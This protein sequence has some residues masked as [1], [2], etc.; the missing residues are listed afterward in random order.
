MMAKAGDVMGENLLQWWPRLTEEQRRAAEILGY[1]SLSDRHRAI[2][3]LQEAGALYR[4]VYATI[5]AIL[6]GPP[7][8]L[9]GDEAL[10]AGER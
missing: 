9:E 2:D 3:G 1:H 8:T 6:Q 4:A 10:E 7:Y 5:A